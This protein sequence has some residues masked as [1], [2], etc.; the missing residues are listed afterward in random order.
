MHRAL[1]MK[2]CTK[3]PL[4]SIQSSTFAGMKLSNFFSSVFSS[5]MSVV[6]F[7]QEAG[8]V[9]MNLACVCG[10]SM[11][12]ES[13]RNKSGNYSVAWRCPKKNCRKECSFLAYKRTDGRLRSS[14]TLR[15]I[16]EVVYF[17]LFTQP[18]HRQLQAISGCSAP[19]LVDWLNLSREVCTHA[20]LNAPKLKRTSSRPVQIDEGYFQ[21][22]RKYSRGRLLQGDYNANVQSN[23]KNNYGSQVNGPWVLGVYESCCNVR[24]IVIPDRR[25]VTILPIIQSIVEPGSVIVTDEWAAYGCLTEAGYEHHTV[26]HTENYVDPVSGYHTQGIERAWVDA[27][28]WLKR[29]R[30]PSHL[31]QSHLDELSWRKMH[32]SNPDGVLFAFFVDVAKYY[33]E[34]S[35]SSA[36]E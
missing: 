35:N 3:E 22:R 7:L 24:F 21:G 2:W 19:T 33:T 14:M 18:T 15:K 28:A 27:K 13:R 5:E 34:Y 12:L 23:R 25:S 31:I 8:V 16:I 32:D 17:W 36:E 9:S 11:R 6:R 26:N 4:Y 20:I 30:Y 29:S 10:S 1:K